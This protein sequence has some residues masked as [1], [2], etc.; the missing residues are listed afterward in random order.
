MAL[1]VID[2]ITSATATAF[3]NDHLRIVGQA[4]KLDTTNLQKRFRH[5]FISALQRYAKVLK[6]KS[7]D[8][9]ATLSR[10]FLRF[11]KYNHTELLTI[12][13]QYGII[14]AAQFTGT[15]NDILELI[16]KHIAEG[17]CCSSESEG[18]CGR[19][20][21]SVNAENGC[22]D[23]APVEYIINVLTVLKPRLSPASLRHLLDNVL[24]PDISF[25]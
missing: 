9:P 10:T 4:I 25:R 7:V 20:A 3:S 16:L 22:N 8:V 11:E 12:V 14:L 23:P 2:I 15:V 1:K 17:S 18:V 6:T 19:F 21:K 24:G 13:S 5:P